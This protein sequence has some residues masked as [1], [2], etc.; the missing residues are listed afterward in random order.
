MTTDPPS[1]PPPPPGRIDYYAGA[2]GKVAD[3]CLGFFGVGVAAIVIAFLAGMAGPLGIVV[4]FAYQIAYIWGIAWG[5]KSG[6][7]F[8][9]IGMLATLLVP[10]IVIGACFVFLA[11]AMS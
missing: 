11:G 10:L 2:G 9:A 3:F 1:T 4:G 5:F 7:R 6:R 8:V